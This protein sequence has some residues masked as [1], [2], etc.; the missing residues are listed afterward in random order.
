MN[1]LASYTIGHWTDRKALTGCTVLLFDR[2]VPAAFEVR[3][4]APGTRETDLLRSNA[5]VRS[6]DA[7]VLSGGSAPGLSAA[8]GVVRYLQ[9]NQR[10]F[11]TPAGPVPIVPAAV[12]F[13]LAV[14]EARSPNSENGYSACVSAGDPATVERGRIG[15]GIG[16]R[17]GMVYPSRAPALGGFGASTIRFAGG[18]V[19]AY[20]VVNAAGE[21]ITPDINADGR[22]DLL[23]MRLPEEG[24]EATTIGVVVTDAPVD[25]RTLERMAIAAHDG[26]AR[27]IRPCHTPWDGDAIF[28]VGLREGSPDLTLTMALGVATELAVE[29]AIQD[30]VAAR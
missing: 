15:A 14:G 23:Q 4:G 7:I 18:S 29:Q 11:P 3:G 21:V 24:R 27:S 26:M 28:A 16:A 8:D 9:E 25:H 19:S 1:D 5:S 6:V 2:L 17:T 20:I 13:D 12:L 10:G 22:H 30:A